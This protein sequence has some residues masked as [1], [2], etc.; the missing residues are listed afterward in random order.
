MPD[1]EREN[2]FIEAFILP[3]RRGRYK[4]LL[5][6]SKRRSDFLDRLNHALDFIPQLAYPIPGSQHSVE[7]VAKLLHQRG[8]QGTDIVYLFSDVREI[9]GLFLPL[10]EAL[11]Q[12]FDA[13]FGSVVSCVAGQLA[14]YRPE[15]PASGYILEKASY[16]TP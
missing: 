13:G 9:D 5:A 16:K 14:Y 8:M 6:S 1:T 11:E 12:V 10:R 4:Q 15:A 7:G 3:E 2:R